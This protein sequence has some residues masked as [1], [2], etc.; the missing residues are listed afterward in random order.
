MLF[1]LCTTSGPSYHLW[2]LGVYTATFSSLSR[3]RTLA[4]S[5]LTCQTWV[6]LRATLFAFV[7]GHTVYAWIECKVPLPVGGTVKSEGQRESS[8][9]TMFERLTKWHPGYREIITV[10]KCWLFKFS[11]FSAKGKFYFS[12]TFFLRWQRLLAYILHNEKA[13]SSLTSK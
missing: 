9:R 5:S 2:P 10:T 13:F 3:L 6:S 8:G 11:D 12:F 4:R 1:P 7:C